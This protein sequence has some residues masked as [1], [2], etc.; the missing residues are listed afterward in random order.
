MI[1]D[2]HTHLEMKDFDDDRDEVVER[3][4]KADVSFMI[5]VGTTLE[6][7]K[8]VLALA[9][10]YK[11]VYAAVGIHPH[12]VKGIDDGTYDNLR[13]LAGMEKV[14]AY[15]EIGLDFFRN[16]SPRQDQIRR[17]GEQLE[18]AGE[19]ALPIIVHDREAHKEIIEMLNPWRG[20]LR[21]VIHCFSGDRNM[22]KKCLDMGFCI[23]VPGTVTY[24]KA[25]ELRNVVQYV[26]LAS[27]LVETDAPYLAPEPHR[28]SRNEP[29]YVVKTAEKVAELKELP[30]GVVAYATSEN[31]KAL[32]GISGECPSFNDHKI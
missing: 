3:A 9:A 8:K 11:E 26:P 17:F 24:L 2:S 25:E 21:G 32:F 29:A 10:Q 13:E 6:D 16:L 19:L 18:I 27:L 31:T 15:G 30:Y 5:T 14:V 23:S 20:K 7:C 1:I 22:A 28:G 12:D 4:R